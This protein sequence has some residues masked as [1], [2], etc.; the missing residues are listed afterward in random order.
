MLLNLD[1]F[2]YLLIGMNVYPLLDLSE[3]SLTK[4][5]FNPIIANLPLL[6]LQLVV[7]NQCSELGLSVFADSEKFL[8]FSLVLPLLH[9]D[10]KGINIFMKVAFEI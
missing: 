4:S 1:S 2:P 5:P 8:H 9:S 6:S 3:R 10:N 7:C